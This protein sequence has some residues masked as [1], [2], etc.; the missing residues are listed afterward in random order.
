MYQAVLISPDGIDKVTDFAGSK[1]IQEVWD[2]LSNMGSRWF[3]YPI[4]FVIT[5]TS[6]KTL[7]KRIVS[8]PDDFIVHK[9]CTVKS[10]MQAIADNPGYIEAILS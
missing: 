5:D 2:K 7:N 9:G 3:F 4:C 8:S 10:A 1:T 6:G